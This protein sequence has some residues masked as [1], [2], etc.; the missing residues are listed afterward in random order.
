MKK[1][2]FKQLSRLEKMH[3]ESSEAGIIRNYLDWI[4]DLPWNILSEDN[5]DLGHAQKVLDEDHLGLKKLRSG[6]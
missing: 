3:T 1:E 4:L 2:A 6:F 5:L